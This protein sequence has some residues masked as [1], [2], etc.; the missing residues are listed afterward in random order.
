MTGPAGRP[1]GT[2]EYL[3]VGRICGVFGV[4]GSVR[5]QSFTRPPGNLLVYNPWYIDGREGRW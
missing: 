4:H 5:V 3:S 2:R 1:P